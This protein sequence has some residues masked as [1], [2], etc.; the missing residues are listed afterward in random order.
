MRNISFALTT[1]QV[2]ARE[3]TVTRRLGWAAL[4]PGTLLMA[5]EK[6]QG[7]KSGEKLVRL[8]AIRVT[9][10]RRERLWLIDEAD[11]AREGFPGMKPS[12][13]VGMFCEHMR[14]GAADLVTRIEFEYLDEL[15][16]SLS[17]AEAR[18]R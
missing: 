18:P 15:A 14:C 3:K 16:D 12:A 10:V 2:R 8:G 13:F 7:L 1:R 6:C 5:C 4:Q 17:P 9:N 11:I